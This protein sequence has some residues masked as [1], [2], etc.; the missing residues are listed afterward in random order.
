MS[1]MAWMSI[2]G[3]RQ[4]VFGRFL[5]VVDDQ[6]RSWRFCRF[7]LKTKLLLN[8]RAEGRP[9]FAIISGI[10]SL[11]AVVLEVLSKTGV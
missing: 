9:D 2:N 4:L 6:D 10:V 8:R 7:E 5:D 1:L 11:G 3:G